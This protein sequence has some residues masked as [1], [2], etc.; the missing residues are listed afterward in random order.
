MLRAGVCCPN[1]WQ[2][3]NCLL[4]AVLSDVRDTSCRMR[5]DVHYNM[6]VD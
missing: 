2:L 5:L 3:S 1:G 4:F 6:Q